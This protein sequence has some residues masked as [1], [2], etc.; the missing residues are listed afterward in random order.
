MS[1]RF[2]LEAWQ[3][4][5]S[6]S[7]LLK[8]SER[9]LGAIPD[10][11]I[12]NKRSFAQRMRQNLDAESF[13]QLWILSR[14]WPTESRVELY[15]AGLQHPLLGHESSVLAGVAADL[16]LAM[17]A[18]PALAEQD[19]IRYVVHGCLE[20][21]LQAQDTLPES[22]AAIYL[23]LW[24]RVTQKRLDESQEL[25]LWQIIARTIQ[26]APR[27]WP[28][29]TRIL[30]M[31]EILTATLDGGTIPPLLSGALLLVS[32]W[33]KAD[34]ISVADRVIPM[35][36]EEF[37]AH[38]MRR[39]RWRLIMEYALQGANVRYPLPRLDEAERRA[40]SG[41]EPWFPSEHTVQHTATDV[42]HAFFQRPQAGQ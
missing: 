26:R 27:Y 22:Y 20:R 42:W 31:P 13:K 33:S 7:G 16:T 25:I 39:P 4:P 8:A 24:D 40:F 14:E 23:A 1:G 28:R 5:G 11:Q 41:W 32:L 3:A 10:G 15:S 18:A 30:M 17:V 21:H 34:G 6:I 2:S 12:A 37:A 29:D 19:H 35:L 36:A 9:I 38:A